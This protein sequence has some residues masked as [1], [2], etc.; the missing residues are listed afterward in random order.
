MNESYRSRDG[1]NTRCWLLPCNV[2]HIAHRSIIKMEQFKNERTINASIKLNYRVYIYLSQLFLKARWNFV[3]SIFDS[4]STAMRCMNSEYTSTNPLENRIHSHYLN[5][6]WNSK[7][8]TNTKAHWNGCT[9]ANTM[10]NL[11]K[12]NVTIK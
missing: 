6:L 10:Q 2:Q 5:I 3:N 12:T 9:C 7:S 1:Q 4:N 8:K 11:N